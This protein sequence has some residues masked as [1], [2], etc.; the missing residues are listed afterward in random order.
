MKTNDTESLEDANDNRNPKKLSEEINPFSR[1]D[2]SRTSRISIRSQDS[3]QFVSNRIEL[4]KISKL[5]K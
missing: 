4:F 1:F 3:Y 2:K 5:F